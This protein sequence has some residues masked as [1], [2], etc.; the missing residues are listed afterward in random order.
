MIRHQSDVVR[1]DIRDAF[2]RQPSVQLYWSTVV[3]ALTVLLASV[4]QRILAS[5]ET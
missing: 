2:W 3:F 4:D 5:T 1:R